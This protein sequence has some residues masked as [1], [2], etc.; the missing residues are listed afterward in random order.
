MTQSVVLDTPVM[1]NEEEE[2]ENLIQDD[3]YQVQHY[4]N[5]GQK[6]SKD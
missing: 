3:E 5:Q 4:N 6:Y 1:D 2:D